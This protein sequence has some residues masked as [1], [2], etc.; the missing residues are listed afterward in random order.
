MNP[1]GIIEHKLS[2]TL[3]H[4]SQCQKC[5][6]IFN[7]EMSLEKCPNCNDNKLPNIVV[8]PFI[9]GIEADN[10]QECYYKYFGGKKT[11]KIN[12]IK[13]FVNTVNHLTAKF[14]SNTSFK[15]SK[16][17]IDEYDWLKFI[18][19]INRGNGI[20]TLREVYQFSVKI[21]RELI[22]QGDNLPVSDETAVNCFKFISTFL[23]IFI[24][25]NN[26]YNVE[27]KNSKINIIF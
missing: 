6:Y 8:L 13:Y 3:E 18:D 20:Y 17:L 12:I 9:A 11:P 7:R 1:D 26:H 10:L 23:E 4:W 2:K 22:K 14:L 27:N 21:K 24:I 16:E 25:L 19:G 15:T 5:R